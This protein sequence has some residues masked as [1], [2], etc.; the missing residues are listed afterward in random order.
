MQIISWRYFI[1]LQ[2]EI[3]DS[4]IDLIFTDPPYG[5]DYLWL[6]KELAKLAVRILKPGGSLVFYV[7]HIILDQVIGIFNNFSLTNNNITKL[8]YWWTLAVKHSGHHQKIYP[9]HV[10]QNGSQYCGM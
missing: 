2:K 4:S 9:R 3:A 6:Y 1:E 7:G 8:K 10:L 5:K